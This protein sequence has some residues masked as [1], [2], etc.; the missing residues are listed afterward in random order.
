MSRAFVKEDAQELPAVR[1]RGGGLP[2]GTPNLATPAGLSALQE[3]LA[4]LVAERRALEGAVDGIGLERRR[5]LDAE[6]RALDAYLGTIEVVAL[7]AAPMRVGFGTRVT[8]AGDAGERTVRIV[9]V[10]EADPAQGAISFVSP[11]ARALFGATA[12]DEVVVTTPSG[13]EAW[14]VVAV[15]PL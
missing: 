2:P 1:A 6:I 9:G 14:E 8:L 13:D 5:A 10:D 11:L 12:G 4:G 7:P 3:E 15:D